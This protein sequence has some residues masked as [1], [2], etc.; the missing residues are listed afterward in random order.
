M[1]HFRPARLKPDHTRW[2]LL[3]SGARGD[4]KDAGVIFPG[5]YSRATQTFWISLLDAVAFSD[6]FTRNI[7]QTMIQSIVKVG[8]VQSPIQRELV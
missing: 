1:R 8:Q 7:L 5:C 2:G 6:E 3:F 4:K